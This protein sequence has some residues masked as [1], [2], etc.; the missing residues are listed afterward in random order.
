MFVVLIRNPPINLIKVILVMKLHE[1]KAEVHIWQ[2][3][4]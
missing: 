2:C 4:T 1:P 3:E